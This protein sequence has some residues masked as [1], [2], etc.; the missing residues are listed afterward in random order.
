MFRIKNQLFF[1]HSVI[2]YRSDGQTVNRKKLSTLEK[3]AKQNTIIKI[4]QAFIIYKPILKNFGSVTSKFL[5]TKHCKELIMDLEDIRYRY[6]A[7]EI[8]VVR[9]YDSNSVFLLPKTIIIQAWPKSS[10]SERVQ[11]SSGLLHHSEAMP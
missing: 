8:F 2:L 10:R 4:S 3:Y 6:F 5:E 11:Y 7:R 1:C 9:F